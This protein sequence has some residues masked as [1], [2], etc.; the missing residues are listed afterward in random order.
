[1]Q[2][3]DGGFTVLFDA[4][5]SDAV[6][7]IDLAGRGRISGGP[8]SILT[9]EFTGTAAKTFRYNRIGWCVLH[10]AGNAGSRVRARTPNGPVASTLPVLISPQIVANGL[11]TPLIPSFEELEVEVAP[12]TWARFEFEGDLFET[13][14]QRNWGDASFKT[15]STP[16]SLGFPHATEAGRTF[17]QA[18]RMTMAGRPVA[19][20]RE[21]P[22]SI[23]ITIE[24]EATSEVPQL[25]LSASSERRPLTRPEAELL[26]ELRLDHLRIDLH[27]GNRNWLDTLA[28]GLEEARAI[29]ASI[30]LAV[31]LPSGIETLDRFATALDAADVPIARVLA[32]REGEA[33]S[34]LATVRTVRAAVRGAPVF[35][36]TNELFVDLN[37]DRPEL[38]DLN[39]VAWPLTATVHAADDT[40]VAETP[41]VHGDTVRSARAF[42]GALPLAVTPVGFHRPDATR[43]ADPRQRSLLGAAWTV[44][45][46]K[47]LSEAGA[48]SLTYFETAGQHGVVAAGEQGRV[49]AFPTY[50]V[51]ADLA[52]LKGGAIVPAESTQALTVIALA[53]SREESLSVLLA[54]LTP[55]HQRCEIAGLPSSPVKLRRLDE[56]SFLSAW[57][58]PR[59]FRV[60]TE[61][62]A[63]R[64]EFDLAPYAVVRLEW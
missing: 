39:G 56:D 27:V 58:D 4:R 46:I 55:T 48:S 17:R 18:V 1:M 14:D 16:L 15:Y 3:E 33:T 59:P 29:R 28:H 42:C 22:R 64:P 30:E 40:S 2:V 61:A 7:G 44:A 20:R 24:A 49:F 21:T 38:D 23:G 51:F 62:K 54:N 19:R 36:G 45:S 53:I 60:M 34:T 43:P 6:Q 47:H 63:Q 12:R 8:G 26:A 52:E 37:R 57:R 10:P 9:C 32:F 41:S 13:E 31:V 50:H 11:P 25:G 5:W 35:G